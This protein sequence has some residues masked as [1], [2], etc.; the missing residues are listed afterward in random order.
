MIPIFETSKLS[1]V[2]QC[3]N[4]DYHCDNQTDPKCPYA[5]VHEG[6][7]FEL[8]NLCGPQFQ[9]RVL[10]DWHV[11]CRL[12]RLSVLQGHVETSL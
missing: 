10:L 3:M 5:F 1:S 11:V 7:E 4:P 6:V 9:L 12:K 2:K 8:C